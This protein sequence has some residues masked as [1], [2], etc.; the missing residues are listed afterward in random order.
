M[1]I[2]QDSA[3]T[4]T[5]QSTKQHR[6]QLNQEIGQITAEVEVIRQQHEKTVAEL[7]KEKEI[8]DARNDKLQKQ[9]EK[10]KNAPKQPAQVLIDLPFKNARSENGAQQNSHDESTLDLEAYQSL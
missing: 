1:V 9:L 3:T 8:A 4:D 5:K 7:T 10:L 2:Q 6:E